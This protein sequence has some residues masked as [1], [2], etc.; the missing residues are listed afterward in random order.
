M[1]F[2]VRSIEYVGVE[3]RTECSTKC[4][5]KQERIVATKLHGVVLSQQC[6]KHLMLNAMIANLEEIPQ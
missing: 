6:R 1:G 4:G 3:S 2:P 5:K